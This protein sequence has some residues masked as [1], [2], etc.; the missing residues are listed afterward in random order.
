[1]S[2]IS[3]ASSFATSRVAT[4]FIGAGATV[5]ASADVDYELVGDPSSTL[6]SVTIS[7]SGIVSSAGST[8]FN[9]VFDFAGDPI[10][11]SP[12]N[13][14]FAG[15][16]WTMTNTVTSQSINGNRVILGNDP[17]TDVFGAAGHSGSGLAF[18]FGQSYTI[19]GSGT[20][21]LGDFGRTFA[22]LNIGTYIA[23]GGTSNI[24]G[25]G[26]LVIRQVPA[27][28]T[29]ALFVGGLVVVSRRRR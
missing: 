16:T 9:P 1:M 10:G 7:G 5:A 3:C 21:D 29:A 17:T 4:A 23:S 25:G 12:A 15:V 6:V 26:S 22:D 24:V 8:V 18:G 19:S 2:F 11:G 20:I 27:P 14:L 28:T 13:S